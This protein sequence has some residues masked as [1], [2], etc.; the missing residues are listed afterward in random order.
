MSNPCI[1][2][3]GLN[4]FWYNYWYSDLFYAD[5]VQQDKMFTELVQLYLKYGTAY[6]STFTY[7]LFWYK[8]AIKP[9]PTNLH[10]YYRW[11]LTK[12]REPDEIFTS[13]LRFETAEVFQTRVSV[14][15][16]N[17]WFILNIY[18]FQPDKFFT[19]RARKSKTLQTA[20][21]LVDV[22]ATLTPLA[23][24]NLLVRKVA[25]GSI[26]NTTTYNF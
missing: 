2:R 10:H 23:K 13:R 20:T 25:I 5:N 7:N 16:L 17:S 15:R 4:T 11:V 18:W 9:R 3:W 8:T 21:S 6:S 26:S 12:G 1:S 24:L 19:K 22:R 14:L